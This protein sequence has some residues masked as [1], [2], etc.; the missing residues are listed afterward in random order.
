MLSGPEV[1]VLL[2]CV[3]C[4]WSGR[5]GQQQLG[6]QEREGVRASE[7]PGEPERLLAG[8]KLAVDAVLAGDAVLDVQVDDPLEEPDDERVVPTLLF[9]GCDDFFCGVLLVAH[10]RGYLPEEGEEST[11][12]AV[13][14]VVSYA[15]GDFFLDR[16]V[17]VSVLVQLLYDSLRDFIWEDC[18][19][20]G[21]VEHGVDG[22][23]ILFCLNV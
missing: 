11:L 21:V 13:V 12:A 3:E 22:S 16:N 2:S 19:G 6:G 20:A 17:E 10:G 7:V 18:G 8:V 4:S 15:V 1:V 23:R 9:E 5:T 14:F